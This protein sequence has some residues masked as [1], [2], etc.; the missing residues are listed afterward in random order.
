VFPFES[1]LT[2]CE[3]LSPGLYVLSSPSF[4][5]VEFPS[6]E[7]I[8]EDMIMDIQ[9]SIELEDLQVGFQIIL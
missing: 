6:D 2:F 1:D 7:A 4:M 8:L 5:N 9:P 3:T